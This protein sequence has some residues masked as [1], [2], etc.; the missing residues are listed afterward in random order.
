M[1]RSVTER[2]PLILQVAESNMASAGLSQVVRVHVGPA[3]DLL[4]DPVGP[5]VSKPDGIGYDLAFIDANKE[6]SKEYFIEAQRL[7]RPGGL[8]IVDNVARNGS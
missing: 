4:R 8:I 7:L 6:Q 3:Y 5:F 1:P 2:T